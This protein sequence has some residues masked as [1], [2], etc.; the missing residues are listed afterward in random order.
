MQILHQQKYGK[1]FLDPP[2]HVRVFGGKRVDRQ[3]FTGPAALEKF[4]GQ[5]LNGVTLKIKAA[6]HVTRIAKLLRIQQAVG[7]P[8]KNW[9]GW[10]GHSEAVPQRLRF[11]GHRFAVPQPPTANIPLST[12]C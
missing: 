6:H 10:L 9:K 2:G 8:L 7:S 4:F 5:F 1:Q 11:L 12:G 3:V